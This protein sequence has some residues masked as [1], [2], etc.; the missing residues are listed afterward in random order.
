M[1]SITA[2]IRNESEHLRED[3]HR[4]R[5]RDSAPEK[6]AAFFKALP[7]PSLL[8]KEDK[9]GGG[10]KSGS[11]DVLISVFWEDRATPANV[12]RCSYRKG[13]L[14]VTCSGTKSHQVRTAD[15]WA[16]ALPRSQ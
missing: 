15:H 7:C 1:Q 11:E 6:Q 2:V 8:G 9:Q 5:G 3:V 12:R 14:P 16:Q 10:W 4:R 13:S